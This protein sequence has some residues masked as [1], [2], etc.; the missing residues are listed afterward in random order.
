GL[1][2]RVGQVAS[3]DVLAPVL[4]ATEV[5]EADACD[6]ELLELRVLPDPGEGDPV[7]DLADLVQRG[8]GVLGDALVGVLGP[9]LHELLGS[10]VRH[11]AHDALRSC[12]TASTAATTRS[13]GTSCDPSAVTVIAIGQIRRME[14]GPPVAASSSAASINASTATLSPSSRVSPG[15]HRFLSEFFAD[16]PPEPVVW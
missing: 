4:I 1:G 12:S 11:E 2:V 16:C 14:S 10:D 3:L 6:P 7:V 13:S 8:T 9:V 15:R 5:R